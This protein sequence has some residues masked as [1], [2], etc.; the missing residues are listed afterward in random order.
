MSHPE[1]H[2]RRRPL[3]HRVAYVKDTRRNHAEQPLTAVFEVI[4]RALKTSSVVTNLIQG[5][6]KTKCLF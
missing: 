3:I 5:V 4:S 2:H 6:T 1:K